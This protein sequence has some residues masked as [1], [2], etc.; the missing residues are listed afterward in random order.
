[1]INQRILSWRK[2]AWRW[3]ATLY[4]SNVLHIG[5]KPLFSV[6]H[7]IHVDCVSSYDMSK[8]IIGFDRDLCCVKGLELK[9]KQK[10]KCKGHQCNQSTNQS[11]H[12]GGAWTSGSGPLI[13]AN[14]VRAPCSCLQ[15]G[16]LE[17]NDILDDNNVHPNNIVSL[18]K[19]VLF[20]CFTYKKTQKAKNNSQFFTVS[21]IGTETL[22]WRIQHEQN[23]L[24][25]FY[26][27]RKWLQNICRL[28]KWFH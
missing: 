15:P 24:I 22:I 3:Y 23:E 18:W 2:A 6:N 27:K 14:D 19:R 17:I 16:S 8:G 1:M 21:Q 13:P 10:H 20:L 12:G 4:L 7:L 9:T 11:N 25:Y 28:K 5:E 26:T